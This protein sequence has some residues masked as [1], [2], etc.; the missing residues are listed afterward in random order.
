MVWHPPETVT[1]CLGLSVSNECPSMP[2]AKTLPRPVLF[3]RT[4]PG[5][6]PPDLCSRLK[7]YT[8]V[9]C[10][11]SHSLT[12]LEVYFAQPAEIREVSLPLMK[13]TKL[14]FKTELLFQRFSLKL[15]GILH[16]SSKHGEF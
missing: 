15:F 6:L 5:L 3:A 7:Q 11:L 4:I 14:L 13:I 12:A 16:F 8:R 10:F 9:A 1:S 2:L